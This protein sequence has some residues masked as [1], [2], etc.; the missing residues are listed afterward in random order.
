MSHPITPELQS[1]NLPTTSKLFNAPIEI[2]R[3]IYVHLINTDGVHVVRT[4][5]GKIRLSPCVEPDLD[6][7]YTGFERHTTGDWSADAVWGR[8]LVSTWGP[9]WKCEEIALKREAERDEEY[10]AV[11]R[12]IGA[13]LRVC[14]RM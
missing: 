4:E 12:N 9:H 8:R 13:L 1:S 3:A 10:E 7:G 5:Q 2:R 11:W 14:R 6:A